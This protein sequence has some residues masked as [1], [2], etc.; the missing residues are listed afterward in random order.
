MNVATSVMFKDTK[1]AVTVVPMFA[2]IMI[3]TAWFKF[4][5]PALTKPTTITVVALLLCITPVTKVP[6]NTPIN[7]FLVKAANISFILLPA[8]F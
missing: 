6:T 2:P 1:N 8:A 7:L 5:K 4:I 3:P